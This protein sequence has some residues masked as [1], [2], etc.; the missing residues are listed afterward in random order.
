MS[1]SQPTGP[2]PPVITLEHPDATITVRPVDGGRR[3]VTVVPNS[4]EVFIRRTEIETTYD[5]D[6]LSAIL[7]AKG[8]SYLCDEIGRDQD[9]TVLEGHLVAA[10]TAHL[11]PTALADRRLL[12]VGCGAGAST[13][14]LGRLL[15]DTEI[16]GVD[17]LQSN[18]DVARARA[19][20]YG[21]DKVSFVWSPDGTRLPELPGGDT[22]PVVVLSAVFEHLLPA[23]RRQLMPMLWAAVEPGGWL[24]IDETPWRW[25]PYESHTVSLPFINYLP[26]AAALRLARR[27]GRIDQTA[28]W[29]E[30]LRDGLRGGTAREVVRSVGGGPEVELVRPTR[31]GLDGWVDLYFAAYGA[32]EGRLPGLKKR[33]R[34][35]MKLVERTTGRS[36]V[37]YLSLALRKAAA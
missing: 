21:M 7:A 24:V 14:I 29:P 34:G 15:P 23:E 9:P 2:L 32:K 3:R 22:F 12:D 33:A 1:D 19:R 36:P 4:P 26:R 8:A 35:A 25:S 16:V 11:D 6:V 27:S 17:L 37:P 5:D 30:L 13:C 10:V 28:T 18:L 20:F 31:L